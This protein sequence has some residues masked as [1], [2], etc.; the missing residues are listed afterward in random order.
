MAGLNRI[1]PLELEAMKALWL[2]GEATVRDVAQ[3]MGRLRPL[4][5]TTVMTLLDRLAR[6]GAA[7][8]RKRGRAHVYHPLLTREAALELALDR[9]ARDENG[10]TSV[11]NVL[12]ICGILSFNLSN[13]ALHG[14][15]VHFAR[16]YRSPRPRI[17]GA[18]ERISGAS[19]RLS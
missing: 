7:G 2:L 9:L 4:A 15:Y 3:E 6:R 14:L 5:Y 8:R 13:V 16:R 11:L 19:P 18:T 17:Q 1:P 12:E 10:V